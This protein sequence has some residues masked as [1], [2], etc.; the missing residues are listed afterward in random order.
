MLL[1]LANENFG[2]TQFRTFGDAANNQHVFEW[3]KEHGAYCY[4]PKSQQESDDIISTNWLYLRCPW[5]VAPIWD[6][7]AAEPTLRPKREQI[8][9]VGKIPPYVRPELYADYPLADL[10]LMCEDAGI[11]VEGDP[12]STDNVRRQLHRYYEGRAWAVEEVKRLKE[13]VEALKAKVAAPAAKKK[14]A[15]RELQPA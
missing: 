3:N 2:N 7:V 4:Q 6:G 13:Q 9:Y 14:A 8:A 10:R 1:K 15:A 12:E 11:A 5:R